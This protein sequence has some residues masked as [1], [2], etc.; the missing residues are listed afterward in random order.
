MAAAG[1]SRSWEGTL[2]LV[3]KGVAPAR[4]LCQACL[5]RWRHDT[6]GVPVGEGSRDRRRS[7]SFSFSF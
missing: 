5:V 4:L 6:E 2:S 1:A 7:F 3:E